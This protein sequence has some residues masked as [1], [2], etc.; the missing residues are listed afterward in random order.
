MPQAALYRHAGFDGDADEAVL[1][2]VLYIW[3]PKYKRYTT[4]HHCST[5]SLFL[6][7]RPGDNLR[8]LGPIAI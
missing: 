4:A 5:A 3:R 8:G 7:Y 1:Y 6:F 2:S